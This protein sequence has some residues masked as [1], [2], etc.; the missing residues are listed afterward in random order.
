[1]S[2]PFAQVVLV[3]TAFAHLAALTFKC[4]VRP[5]VVMST[6]LLVLLGSITP[7][8]NILGRRLRPLLPRKLFPRS[9]AL[10]FPL[11]WKLRLKTGFARPDVDLHLLGI[12]FASP[13]YRVPS[14][15]TP[16]GIGTLLLVATIGNAVALARN[17]RSSVVLIVQ[18]PR[19]FATLVVS[20]NPLTPYS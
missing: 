3:A 20:P 2:W 17:F 15:L 10:S 16:P 7:I 8:L 19:L 13:P 6:V 9:T 1:M 4:Y 14:L 12:L 18:C 11:P 5:Y